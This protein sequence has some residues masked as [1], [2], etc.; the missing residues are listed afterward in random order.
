MIISEKIKQNVQKLPSSLQMEVL[1]FVEYL[2]T[3]TEQEKDHQEMQAWSEFSLA[4]AMRDMED[5]DTPLYS[6]SDLKIT[7]S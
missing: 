5:T 6:L 3:K 7:F 1:N 4:S 2:L